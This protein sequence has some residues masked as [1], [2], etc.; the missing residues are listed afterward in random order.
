MHGAVGERRELRDADVDTHYRV[1][2][3]DRMLDCMFGLDANE[4]LA[5]VLRKDDVTDLA[6]YFTGG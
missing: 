1:R 5:R 4:P 6:E 3:M 2:R